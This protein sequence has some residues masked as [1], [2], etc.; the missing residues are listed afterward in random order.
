MITSGG[1]EG[2]VLIL[3]FLGLSNSEFERLKGEIVNRFGEYES[4]MK[5]ARSIEELESLLKGL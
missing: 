4:W 1:T 5:I 2:R 3:F